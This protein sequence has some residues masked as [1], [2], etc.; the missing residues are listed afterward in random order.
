MATVIYKNIDQTDDSLITD[1]WPGPTPDPPFDDNP[2]QREKPK[3]SKLLMGLMRHSGLIK[4]EPVI[5]PFGF[6]LHRYK[7]K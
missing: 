4:P 6:D 2:P 1:D 3:A 5:N 7:S